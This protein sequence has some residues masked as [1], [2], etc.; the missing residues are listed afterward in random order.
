MNSK[1]L[2]LLGLGVSILSLLA[3]ELLVPAITEEAEEKRL[4]ELV[5]ARIKLLTKE[6]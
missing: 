1:T 3:T 2:K 4:E 6:N 5:D